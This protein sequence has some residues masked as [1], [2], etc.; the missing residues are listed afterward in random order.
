MSS[1]KSRNELYKNP[2][3]N[4][5]TVDLNGLGVLME[6][7]WYL[8]KLLYSLYTISLYITYHINIL[9]RNSH[10]ISRGRIYT[11]SFYLYSQM[12]VCVCV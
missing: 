12:C 4:S 5:M 2:I 7:K 6:G 8:V 10:R 11:L 3:M 9:H 1:C